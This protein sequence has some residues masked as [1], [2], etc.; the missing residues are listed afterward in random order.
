M[1]S[2]ERVLW[3]SRRMSRNDVSD[4]PSRITATSASTLSGDSSTTRGLN[5]MPTERKKSTAKASCSGS[6]SVAARLLSSDSL[7]TAPAKKA[8][9]ANDTPKT[10]YAMAAMPSAVASTASVNSSREPTRATCASSHGTARR[11]TTPISA[12]NAATFAS[13]MPSAV[14]SDDVLIASP[15]LPP[16]IGAIAGSSTST[17][18]IARSSTTSQPTPMRPSGESSRSCASSPLIST[19]VLATAMEIP[20]TRAPPQLSPQARPMLVPTVPVT[21]ICS[22][23]PGT[24]TRRTRRRSPTEKWS[25]T[26]NINRITPTSAAC[27]I[28]PLSSTC[29]GVNGPTTMPASRYPTI[30]GSL[31]RAA[32]SPK[33]KAMPMLAANVTINAVCAGIGES[34]KTKI[35]PK[36]SLPRAD[37]ALRKLSRA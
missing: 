16:S 31:S 19:T 37:H 3:P 25:P 5:R 4:L 34:R 2:A 7:T 29:T 21:S 9:S 11:P 18:T 27:E 1:T 36:H 26:P 12:A 28:M 20:R 24:T 33:R 35:R 8:P 10:S 17:S 15:S 22:S 23:A 14:A 30:G 6:A 13:E 32:A